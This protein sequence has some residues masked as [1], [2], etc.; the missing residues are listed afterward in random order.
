MKEGEKERYTP[1]QQK[2]LVSGINKNAAKTLAAFKRL[3][4][5]IQD[6]NN[7]NRAEADKGYLKF[8]TLYT[9]D[10]GE[11]K[12]EFAKYCHDNNIRL[13]QF[14]PAE[15]LKT[16]LGIVERFNRSMRLY[17]SKLWDR[18]IELHL[19]K[20]TL[21][22]ALDEIV[23]EHNRKPAW[24]IA[25]MGLN[26]NG[27]LARTPMDLTVKNIESEIME[28]KKEKTEEVDEHYRDVTNRLEQGESFRYFLNP[29][30]EKKKDSFFKASEQPKL[31]DH[32]GTYI[33]ERHIT[34]PGRLRSTA[35]KEFRTNTY[36]VQGAN[37]RVLPYDVVFT[38]DQVLVL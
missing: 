33:T 36:K 35:N 16:R 17:L 15:G 28:R 18:K 6:L 14:R 26:S 11:F 5:R 8:R 31:S 23:V 10:G 32:R 27:H 29:A 13:V 19:P 21:Q 24:G 38:S 22:Q 12:G 4:K 3:M 1:Q 9:D 7:D 2:T 34:K 20:P 37:R 25:K 30:I